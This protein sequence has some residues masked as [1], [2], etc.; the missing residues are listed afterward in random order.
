MLY[1][2]ADAVYIIDYETILPLIMEFCNKVHGMA[3]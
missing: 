2:H 3:H 1:S